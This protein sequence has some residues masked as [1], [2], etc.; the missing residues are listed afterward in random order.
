MRLQNLLTLAMRV[1]SISSIFP[2]SVSEDQIRQ[3]ICTVLRVLR[4]QYKSKM[5]QEG[6]ERGDVGVDFAPARPEYVAVFTVVHSLASWQQLGPG[7][8][9]LP[10]DLEVT[11]L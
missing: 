6:K 8:S 9:H 4:L 2:A 1:H 7:L 10:E 5:C 3:C 11:L